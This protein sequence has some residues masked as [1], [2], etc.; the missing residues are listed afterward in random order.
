MLGPLVSLGSGVGTGFLDCSATRPDEPRAELTRLRWTLDALDAL[1][2]GA[3][4]LAP[5]S[6]EAILS[7]DLTF[8]LSDL[9]RG[10]LIPVL[11]PGRMGRRE[12]TVAE[13]VARARSVGLR[14]AAGGPRTRSGA[15]FDGLVVA[16]D[17]AATD[18]DTDGCE[19]VVASGLGDRGDIDWARGIGAGVGEGP[20]L[21]EPLRVAPVDVKRL[22]R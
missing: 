3:F 8:A 15:G 16:C 19:F 7:D 13:A 5:L 4:L 11:E 22:G 14:V 9:E 2:P 6:A 21:A 20:A 18:I 17:R 10:R 12:S 1:S